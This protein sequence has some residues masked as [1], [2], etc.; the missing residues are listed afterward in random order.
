LQCNIYLRCTVVADEFYSSPILYEPNLYHSYSLPSDNKRFSQS[1]ERLLANDTSFSRGYAAYISGN[2]TLAHD[3]LVHAPAWI[4]NNTMVGM[5]SIV[6]D[7]KVGNNVVI[8][9]GSIVTGVKI[10]D[11]KLV[12]IGS[13]ITN[14]TQA[15][16]LPSAIG[17]PSQNLNQADLLNSQELAEAYRN[18]VIK[19]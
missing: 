12:P 2:T 1:G 14:Q 5:K 9:L 16:R 7:A 3:S 17:T 15:D 4:G 6:F 10:A 13:I 19:K 8:R 11:N 18:Q